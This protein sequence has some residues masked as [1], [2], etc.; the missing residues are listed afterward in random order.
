MAGEQ[1]DSLTGSER[2]YT[3]FSK[4][5]SISETF[6]EGMDEEKLKQLNDYEFLNALSSQDRKL[7][8]NSWRKA[9]Y[10]KVGF[11]SIS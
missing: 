11:I 3:V 6:A 9:G 1:D 8:S 4:R 7:S 2:R 5:P 10:N